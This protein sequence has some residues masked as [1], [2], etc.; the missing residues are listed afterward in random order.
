MIAVDERGE[1][2]RV[3]ADLSHWSQRLDVLLEELRQEVSRRVD[4][5]PRE[6][7]DG[8]RDDDRP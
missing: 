5:E 8:E 7:R 6:G 4:T 2:A 3:V 1:T